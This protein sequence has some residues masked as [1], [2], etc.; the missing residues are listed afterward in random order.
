MDDS[1]GHLTKEGICTWPISDGKYAQ[2]CFFQWGNIT[3]EKLNGERFSLFPFA[4]LPEGAQIT[5]LKQAADCPEG[6][7][8]PL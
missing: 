8:L 1:C 6:L 3:L 2:C 7:L 4:Q 5:D